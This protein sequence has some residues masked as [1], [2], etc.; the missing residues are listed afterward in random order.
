[1]AGLLQD[2]WLSHME[3]EALHISIFPASTSR[4]L[5]LGRRS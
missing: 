3:R 5:R 1:M 4:A 2:M